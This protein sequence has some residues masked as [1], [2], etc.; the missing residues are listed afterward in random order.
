MSSRRN[1][2]VEAAAWIAKLSQTRITTA[3]LQEFSAWRKDP[4]NDAA[5]RAV[6]QSVRR[7]G[8]R[9]VFQPDARGFSVIDTWTGDPAEFAARP[10]TGISKE[11]ARD[12]AELLNRRAIRGD[13]EGMQ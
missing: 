13:R 5:Y 8:G 1:P 4:A 3:E 6:E 10:Q 2:Q 11:D 12:I 7:R 9:F